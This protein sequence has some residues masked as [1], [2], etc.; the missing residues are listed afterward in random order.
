VQYIAELLPIGKRNRR[1]SWFF[2][3]RSG[4]VGLVTAGLG[5]PF[6]RSLGTFKTTITRQDGSHWNC[7]ERADC[8]KDDRYRLMWDGRH[9]NCVE[10]S[11]L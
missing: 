2:S 9:W 7:V 6:V 5:G 1:V 10:N 4:G 11:R 8:I 3:W